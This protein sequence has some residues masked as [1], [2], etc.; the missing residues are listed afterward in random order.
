MVC[1]VTEWDMGEGREGGRKG[2]RERD[3]FLTL[4]SI[5]NLDLLLSY[6]GAEEM[7][8]NLLESEASVPSPS[9]SFA[10]TSDIQCPKP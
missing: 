4:C 5:R 2:K 10:W 7:S 9:L 8:Q 1:V 3:W 6:S